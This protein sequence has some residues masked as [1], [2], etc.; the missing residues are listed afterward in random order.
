MGSSMPLGCTIRGDPVD[1]LPLAFDTSPGSR[2]FVT[3]S[4]AG[5]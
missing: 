2:W 4:Y 3:P 5:S 1:S